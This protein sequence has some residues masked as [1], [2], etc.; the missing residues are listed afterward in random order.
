MNE[1]FFLFP[2]EVHWPWPEKILISIARVNYFAFK[3]SFSRKLF[4]YKE[5]D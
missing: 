3:S 2:M 1:P 5:D 4:M